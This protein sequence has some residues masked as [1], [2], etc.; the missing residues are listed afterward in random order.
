M[1]LHRT[2]AK[3]D[4]ENIKA[5]QHNAFQK[6][7]A[8]TG[9]FVTPANIVTIIGFGI[10][11]Y[12]LVCIFNQQYWTGLIF[13]AIG[14]LLDIVDGI[15]ADKT[16]T[17]SPLGEIFDA[18]ADKIGTLFTIIVI[19][20]A[21]IT[22][23]WIILALIIPQVVIPML[24]LYKKG[25]G[26]GIHPTR[27]GKLSMALTWVGIVGL[28]ILKASGSPLWLAVGVYV[29]IG[30]SLVLGLYALWQYSTGRDQ[31]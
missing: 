30:L 14:R 4:W 27:P 8:A 1:N 22:N 2:S 28:L 17:K 23:L 25:K 20:L 19:I 12:G 6:L 5:S 18:V 3:P 9:G 13:L 10:V 29:I 11:I 21:D 16:G 7:A 15:V 26:I 31:D 24:I